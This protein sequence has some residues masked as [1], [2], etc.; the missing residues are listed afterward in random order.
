MIIKHLTTMKKTIL[1]MVALIATTLCAN[2]QGQSA[3]LQQG[4]NLTAF[5]GKDAFVQAYGAAKKGAVIT[6][7]AGTFT[8]VDSIMKEISIIGNGYKGEK[9]AFSETSGESTD[10]TQIILIGDNI[11]LEGLYLGRVRIRKTNNLKITHCYIKILWGVT[12]NSNNTQFGDIHKNT[13]VDQCIIGSDVA[14]SGEN[15][16][17]KNSIINGFN[18]VN[19]SATTNTCIMNCLCF[20]RLIPNAIFKNCLIGLYKASYTDWGADWSSNQECYNNVFFGGLV[21]HNVSQT[22]QDGTQFYNLYQTIDPEMR[23]VTPEWATEESQT[24]KGNTITS[25]DAVFGE[26]DNE[27]PLLAP[28]ITTIKGDDGKVVGPYGGTGFS[29]NPSIPRI[30]ESNIDS[31]T[32]ADG[33]LNVK[34]KVEVNN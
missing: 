16:C 14:T 22:L 19:K 33:K 30:V 11:T 13:I 28:I 8:K 3:T 2:A 1:L 12:S 15:Y 27:N 31:Y 34:V 6:L 7:S 25:Y 10:S 4:D 20:G 5:Y 23:W 9:T 26:S 24:F 32:D 21:W 29:E 18:R 17:I